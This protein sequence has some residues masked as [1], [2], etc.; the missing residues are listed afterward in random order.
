MLHCATQRRAMDL[1]HAIGAQVEDTSSDLFKGVVTRKTLHVGLHVPLKKLDPLERKSP[2]SAG[3]AEPL[4]DASVSDTADVGE[5]LSNMIKQVRCIMSPRTEVDAHNTAS[6]TVAH[7][8]L[9]IPAGE[10]P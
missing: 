10:L 5:S 7:L 3:R 1:A 4:R 8:A 9:D 6:G 2:S